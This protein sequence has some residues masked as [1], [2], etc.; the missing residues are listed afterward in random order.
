[1]TSID[2]KRVYGDRTGATVAYV[3]SEQ[4]L[5]RLRVSGA[6]VGEFGLLERTP[7]R[8]L[9]VD[10]ASGDRTTVALATPD[11][12]LVAIASEDRGGGRGGDAGLEIRATG[13]GPATAVG[14]H[15][16][17][18]LAATDEGEVATRS[19]D[20]V[21]RDPDGVGDDDWRT[22]TRGVRDDTMGDDATASNAS[23]STV[24]AIDG[25]LVA[26]DRGLRRVL[27]DRL[28]DAGLEDVRAVSAPGVPLA[29]TGD[30]LYKLGNG[31][32][33]LLEGA[34]TTVTADPATPPGSISSA[35]AVDDAGGLWAY[36]AAGSH[37]DAPPAD[38]SSWGQL[39]S[40]TLEAAGRV[41]DV[42]YGE[43]TYAVTDDG[44]LLAS[45][46][47]TGHASWRSHPI[48]LTG[49]NGLVVDPRT[50]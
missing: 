39:Q 13:F 14:I 9:A 27:D 16:G 32:M 15:D 12:V 40:G 25:P 23:G 50:R 20:H 28:V 42:A 31:W 3:A 10:T 48:G 41:V 45:T 22:V 18:L 17:S 49:V 34:F 26:T 33:R 6:S 4:G 36:D 44:V 7:I 24:C 47:D 46:D 19:L 35:H 37:S 30:G 21:A 11:D 5:C 29:A 2:E 8:G 38:G 43:R 1:M